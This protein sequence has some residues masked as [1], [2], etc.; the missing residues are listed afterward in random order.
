MGA[1]GAWDRRVIRPWLTARSESFAAGR[2]VIGDLVRRANF[3]PAGTEV[4]LAVSGGPDSLALVVLA[5]EAELRARIVHVDHGIRVGS[6]RDFEVVAAAADR[7]GFS[8]DLH[9]L[10]VPPGPNLEA[11]A[12]EARRSVLPEGYMTGH[13][14]DD[15]AETVLLALLRGAGPWGLGA[16]SSGFSHPLLSIRRH[17]TRA[18][19][20]HVGLAPVDDHTN[21]DPAYRRN[22]VRNE[23]LPM[24]DD[25]GGRDCVPI[26]ARLARNQ[27]DVATELDRAA[28]AVDPTDA[29]AVRALPRPVFVAAMRGWWRSVTGTEHTPDSAALDRMHEV[30]SGLAPRRDVTLGWEIAR[31][32]STLRLQQRE[33]HGSVE[34]QG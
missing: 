27:R 8:A 21:A 28:N 34:R 23:L 13:T 6:E 33:R 5:A 9:R 17:E 19:C 14:A 15:Q 10:E 24:L 2:R 12:R 25:I 32:A 3:P 11:R 4:V 7:F 16:M 22:R 1:T 18:L 26:I 20:V 31:T 29:R 30:A